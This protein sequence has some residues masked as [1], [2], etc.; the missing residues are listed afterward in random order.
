VTDQPKSTDEFSSSA[1]GLPLV[2]TLAAHGA[3]DDRAPKTIEEVAET[4]LHREEGQNSW[5]VKTTRQARFTFWLFSKVMK[6]ERSKTLINDVRQPD[7][8]HFSEFLRSMHKSFGKS[9][10]DLE[11]T[12]AQVR[13]DSL[14]RELDDVGLNVVTHNRHL[15][16]LGKL[17]TIAKETERVDSHINT[18]E[19]VAKT[20]IRAR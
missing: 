1:A 18:S 8:E 17:F 12:I 16:F 5:D 3:D 14:S 4:L 7:V 2:G 10:K 20:P 11:K 19:F 6:E 15:T 13:A 9:P